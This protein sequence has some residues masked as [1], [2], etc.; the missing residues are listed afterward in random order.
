MT[1]ILENVQVLHDDDD[2]AA[3]ANDDDN[4]AMTIPRRF[5]R[6]QPSQKCGFHGNQSATDQNRC[7]IYEIFWT[8]HKGAQF[9]ENLRDVISCSL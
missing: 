7:H 5:L 4:R 9:Q 6:K 8:R 3:A 1:E 2:D